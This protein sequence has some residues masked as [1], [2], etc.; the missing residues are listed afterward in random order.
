[1]TDR[2]DHLARACRQ[3]AGIAGNC[4]RGSLLVDAADCLEECRENGAL[5]AQAIAERNQAL[6]E[7]AEANR[8]ALRFA[9]REIE[10]AKALGVA[11]GS[12]YVPDCVE[13]I[14]KMAGRIHELEG[15]IADMMAESS[16]KGE[17]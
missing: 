12:R 13:A 6:T 5:L 8:A 4:E 1:M 14:G 2:I 11:T 17:S 9:N 7:R 15:E 10:V 3:A 16:R